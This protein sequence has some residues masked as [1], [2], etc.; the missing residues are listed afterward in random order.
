MAEVW[1]NGPTA[2]LGVSLP[3]FPNYYVTVGPNAL[4][5]SWGFTIGNQTNFISKL[6][7]L[8]HTENLVALEPKQDAYENYNKEID[9]ALEN[10]VY[11]AKNVRSWYKVS[12]SFS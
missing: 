1:K 3:S 8:L 6:V 12:D 7:S 2:H 4:S 5:T 11:V 10:S 9:H